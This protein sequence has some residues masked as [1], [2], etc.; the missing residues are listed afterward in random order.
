[1]ISVNVSFMGKSIT[2]LSVSGHANFADYG[3]DIV[4][5]GVSAIVIGGINALHEDNEDV[6]FVIKSNKLAIH[7]NNDSEKIQHILY[8]IY[9][10]LQTI[11]ETYNKNLKIIIENN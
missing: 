7:V 1:M 11:E 3:K 6:S 10:Q 2:S 8:T 5:A 4:C 9:V